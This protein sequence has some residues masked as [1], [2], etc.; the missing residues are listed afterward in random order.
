MKGDDGH[1]SKFNPAP[2]ITIPLPQVKTEPE[3]ETRLY[4]AEE[5]LNALEA[6]TLT[7]IRIQTTRRLPFLRRN[8]RKG[9][10]KR[11]M[12]LHLPIYGDRKTISLGV[13]YEYVDGIVFHAEIEEWLCPL[14]NIFGKFATR[15]MLNRHLEWD[16]REV[17]CEWKRV[18]ET[19]VSIT[20]AT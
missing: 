8:L 10:F 16:H 18:E 15:A 1:F 13:K 20:L 19:D 12:N 5:L 17:F 3:G 4:P 9:F 11:C 6:L 14:C 2:R 7:S